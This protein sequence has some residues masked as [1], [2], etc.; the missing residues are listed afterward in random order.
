MSVPEI[1][2]NVLD[3]VINIR[4]NQGFNSYDGV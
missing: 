3:D 2:T 4:S 1:G